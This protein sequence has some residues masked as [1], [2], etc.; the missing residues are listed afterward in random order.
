MRVYFPSIDGV[1]YPSVRAAINLE[2]LSFRYVVQS[3]NT[4]TK[5]VDCQ[6]P[7]R[8]GLNFS[9]KYVDNHPLRKVNH[10][11]TDRFRRTKATSEE[12][13]QAYAHVPRPFGTIIASEIF[14]SGIMMSEYV[15]TTHICTVFHFLNCVSFSTD[16]RQFELY[17]N[18]TGLDVS[19]LLSVYAWA[20]A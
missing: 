11:N 19:R 8:L 4:L 16:F 1:C 2:G 13:I 17:L 3:K 20:N 14:G 15:H 18:V 10:R 7:V 5:P 9:S 6:L 12:M